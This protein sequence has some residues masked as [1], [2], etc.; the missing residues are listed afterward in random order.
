MVVRDQQS[1]IQLQRSL[2]AAALAGHSGAGTV[3][4]QI[5]HYLRCK[6]QEMGAVR[7][8]EPRSVNQVDV[9]LVNQAGRVVRVLSCAA[10]PLVRQLAQT[11]VD[12]WDELIS[13]ALVS[14]A[15]SLQE[16]CNLRWHGCHTSPPG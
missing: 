4:E 3:D 7:Q 2:P 16:T 13:R 12:E 15:P 14:S 11:I 9:R 10:Q 6:R 1:F 8:V 5:P